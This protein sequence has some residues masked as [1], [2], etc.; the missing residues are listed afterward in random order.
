MYL[1]FEFVGRVKRS[2]PATCDGCLIFDI[3]IV[4]IRRGCFSPVCFIPSLFHRPVERTVGPIAG[5]AGIT[6]FNRIVVDI[7]HVP[8]P[9]GFIVDQVLPKSGLPYLFLLPV[10]GWCI[11]V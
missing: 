9:I 11:K 6:V 5:I 7:I 10:V 2:G 1:L 3:H 8:L 4:D